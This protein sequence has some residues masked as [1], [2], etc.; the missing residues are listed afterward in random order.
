MHA[1]AGAGVDLADGA[2]GV[3][4]ALGDVGGEEVDAADVE[5]DG[6]D[7]PLGHQLVVGVDD[8]G[9]VDGG[10]AGG[11]VGGLAQEDDLALGRDG[12]VVVAPARA[13]SRSAASSSSS[14][15][16]MFSWPAPRRGSL[17]HL[18]DQLGDGGAAVAHDVAGDAV[19]GGD[20]LAVDDEQAVV[21]A[22]DHALDDHARAFVDRRS[23]RRRRPR[24]RW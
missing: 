24:R 22:L 21:V 2:A 15:V 4:V 3:A 11:E 7:R 13:S 12:V 1:H 16:S 5:A 18:R 23:R 17:V 14:R 9:D 19:G 20:E 6:A 8:V 10:A